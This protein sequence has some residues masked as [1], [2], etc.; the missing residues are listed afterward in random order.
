MKKVVSWVPIALVL[1]LLSCNADPM[2]AE[3]GVVAPENEGLEYLTVTYHSEGHTSGEPPVDERRYVVPRLSTTIP[4][5]FIV[6]PEMAPVMGPGTLEK[7]GFNWGGWRHRQS[8][9]MV[10]PMFETFGIRENT[11]FDAVWFEILD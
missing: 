2:D 1:A 4:P 11:D 10:H 6:R 8:G 7:D 3:T 9:E 5:Y